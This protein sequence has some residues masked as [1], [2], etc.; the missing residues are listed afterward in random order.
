VT[1]VPRAALAR[2]P[3]KPVLADPAG[4]TPLWVWAQDDWRPCVALPRKQGQRRGR[5]AVQFR[6]ATGSGAA[7]IY[8]GRLRELRT[9]DV[10]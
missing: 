4:G 3:G 6:S 8:M 1:A 7:I 10:Q 5:T 9:R 2:A